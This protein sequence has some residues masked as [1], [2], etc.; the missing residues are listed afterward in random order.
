MNDWAP[1]QNTNESHI[2]K[3]SA[4]VYMI[5]FIFKPMDKIGKDI[6]IKAC[7][8]ECLDRLVLTCVAK[9]ELARNKFSLPYIFLHESVLALQQYHLV[10]EGTS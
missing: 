5:Y 6:Y 8:S 7:S 1:S 10:R 4:Q 9:S 3:F 2:V